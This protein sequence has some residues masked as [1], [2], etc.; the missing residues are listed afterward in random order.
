MGNYC[1]VFKVMQQMGENQASVSER[2]FTGV[3]LK[4]L[5]LAHLMQAALRRSGA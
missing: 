5:K 2:E 3:F 4:Y 1:T